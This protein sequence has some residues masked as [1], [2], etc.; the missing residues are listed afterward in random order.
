MSRAPTETRKSRCADKHGGHSTTGRHVRC[1]PDSNFA[2]ATLSTAE[3]TANQYIPGHGA[4]TLVRMPQ[5]GGVLH[6]GMTRRADQ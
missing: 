1:L 5:S 4:V 3:F 6:H 2:E